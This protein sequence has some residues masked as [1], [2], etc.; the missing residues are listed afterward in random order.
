MGRGESKLRRRAEE[1]ERASFG[2]RSSAK[3]PEGA[4]GQE[5]QVCSR[6]CCPSAGS[7]CSRVARGEGWCCAGCV[8]K[9]TAAAQ[10]LPLEPC[11]VARGT[12]RLCRGAGLAGHQPCRSGA[13]GIAQP[14]PARAL[15]SGPSA[16]P[17]QRASPKQG[18]QSPASCCLLQVEQSFV[19]LSLQA[20]THFLRLKQRECWDV[21]VGGHNKLISCLL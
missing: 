16:V 18:Q 12:V 11:C 14:G 20:P 2:E 17:A 4:A 13:R 9:S 21:A 15:S 10:G 19:T 5:A 1:Q 6:L 3:P 8:K 7:E